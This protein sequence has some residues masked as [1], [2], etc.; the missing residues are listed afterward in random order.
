M[1]DAAT[2]LRF[3]INGLTATGVHFAVLASLF[4]GGLIHSA[5]MANGLAAVTGIIASYVGNHHFV[6]RSTMN[7][8]KTIPAF[9][10][11]YGVVAMLHAGVLAVWTDWAGLPYQVGFLIATSCS[12]LVTF[13]GNRLFVFSQSPSRN[14]I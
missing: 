4:E 12:L 10:V 11:L 1:A 13:M 14:M 5:W 2:F 6:F 8:G 9:F 3:I 7:Y